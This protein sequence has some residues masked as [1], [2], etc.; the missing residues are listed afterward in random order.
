LLY[1]DANENFLMCN[2]CERSK[3][4]NF[5]LIIE[6]SILFEKLNIT[7]S[8]GNALQLFVDRVSKWQERFSNYIFQLRKDM[9]SI[10]KALFEKN[11]SISAYNLLPSLKKAELN[12]IYIEGLLLEV[13]TDEIKQM[14][15][16]FKERYKI[17]E[18]E[19]FKLKIKEI[20]LLNAD[21]AATTTTVNLSESNVIFDDD[22]KMKNSPLTT[23]ATTFTSIFLTDVK[24]PKLKKILS[25]GKDK[26]GDESSSNNKSLNSSLSGKLS[27]NK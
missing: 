16:I 24:K 9:P 12:D 3:R 5:D 23:N 1:F 27:Q 22:I 17:G 11:T 15:N 26:S 19:Q 25:K 13:D 10:E 4:P 14:D 6:Q 20:S 7:S 18:F 2:S 21:S 8:E